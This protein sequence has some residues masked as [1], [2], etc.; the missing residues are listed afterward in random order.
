[1]GPKI[2]FVCLGNIC[3]SPAAEGVARVL[4]STQ[5]IPAE[6]DSAGLGDWHT[7]EP[8]HGTMQTVAEQRGYPIADLRARQI[9]P[10]DLEHFDWIVGMDSAN[11]KGLEDLRK[12]CG[13]KAKLRKLCAQD[14]PDPYYGG[15]DGFY[16]SFDMIHAGVVQLFSDLGMCSKY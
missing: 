10:A 15:V 4:A 14:V 5:G 13:G 16:R 2:L 9:G 3:R 11:M 8:P 12:R 7:G 1:M 6:L